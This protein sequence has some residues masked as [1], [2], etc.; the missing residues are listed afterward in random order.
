MLYATPKP[1]GHKETLPEQLFDRVTGRD[2]G[3]DERDLLIVS[4]AVQ[5]NLILATADRNQ[6]MRSIEQAAKS[7][8]AKGKPVHLQVAE[9]AVA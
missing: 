7:L 8:E 5:Y 1:R 2:L 4:V 6:G 3:I 9:W